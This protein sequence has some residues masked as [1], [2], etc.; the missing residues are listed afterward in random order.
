MSD[1]QLPERDGDGYLTDMGDWSEDVA[2]A[3]ATED[4][5]ELDASRWTQVIEARAYYETHST[6]PPV[7]KFARYLGIN[8]R[9]LFDL[10]MT[11]PMKPITK[12]GG[13]PKPTGCV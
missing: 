2:R 12:Y 8:T 11:G 13:L 5:F 4:G 10:W 1:M 7:R 3:M 6:V 9:E